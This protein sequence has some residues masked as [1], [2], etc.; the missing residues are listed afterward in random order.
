MCFFCL[1]KDFVCLPPSWPIMALARPRRAGLWWLES[2]KPWSPQWGVD[3]LK[4]FEQQGH[5]LK[6]DRINSVINKLLFKTTIKPYYSLLLIQL[7]N[8][9][10]N[11]I[12]IYIIDI[13]VDPLDYLIEKQPWYQ[14]RWMAWFPPAF[15]SMPRAAFV[16]FTKAP[17]SDMGSGAQDRALVWQ[18][19]SYF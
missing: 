1:F 3:Y 11:M 19:S 6:Q 18:Q 9:K 13:H 8:V 12:Y 5:H 17:T 7:N 2:C 10:H 4:R 15:I 16:F 14:W